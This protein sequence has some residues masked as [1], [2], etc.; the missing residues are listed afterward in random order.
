[1]STCACGCVRIAHI[2]VSGW[3]CVRIWYIVKHMYVCYIHFLESFFFSANVVDLIFEQS[4]RV[5]H[6]VSAFMWLY[7]LR[8]IE[9]RLQ[10]H[11]HLTQC[12]L[13]SGWFSL[14]K[15]FWQR[16]NFCHTIKALWW[17][18]THRKLT[19]THTA[20]FLDEYGKKVRYLSEIT[21]F[22]NVCNGKFV[23]VWTKMSLT[24]PRKKKPK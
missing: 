7:M 19:A 2:I 20:K 13:H 1:M 23:S 16:T 6:S 3:V 4:L 5:A 21:L 11:I 10:Y 18:D 24:F 8:E 15:Q 14:C 17:N 9:N 12:H 22:N